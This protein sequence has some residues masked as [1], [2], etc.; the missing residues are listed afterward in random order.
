MA[1]RPRI[2]SA[3]LFTDKVVK[4][5][6]GTEQVIEPEL[7]EVIFEGLIVNGY[8]KRGVLTDKFF[9][10]KKNGAVEV[11]EEV[12][13][14]APDVIAIIESIYDPRAFEIG[15]ARKNNVELKVSA[16]KLAMP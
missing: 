13:T 5:S 11:A 3:A 6:N 10:D 16:D 1:D 12:K 9:E 14:C 7:A 2:V 8:V 15:N 4:D